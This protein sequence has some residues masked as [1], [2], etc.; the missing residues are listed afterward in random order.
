M[1]Q[2]IRTIFPKEFFTNTAY[3]RALVLGI[4]YLGVAIAQLFTYEKFAE[5]LQGFGLPGGDL[6][7]AV[8]AVVSPLLVCAALP[9]LLS[10]RLDAR[11][12]GLTRAAVVAAPSLWFVMAVWVNFAPN[13]SKLNAGVFGATIPT[14]VGLWVIAFTVL[15]VWA[16]VLVVREL[17]VRS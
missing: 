2:F 15:W 7:A 13:A 14:A 1:K 8:L 16:A 11:L 3:F 17:P 4:L 5:V 12:R 9:F 6:T 10:M